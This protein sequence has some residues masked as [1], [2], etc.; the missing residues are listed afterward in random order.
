MLKTCPFEIDSTFQQGSSAVLAYFPGQPS[1]QTLL[2]STVVLKPAFLGSN[3]SFWQGSSTDHSYISRVVSRA[4]W[5]CCNRQLSS[6][7]PFLDR[8][9]DLANVR[10]SP[11]RARGQPAMNPRPELSQSVKGIAINSKLYLLSAWHLCSLS[12]LLMLY[13]RDPQ[14]LA[15]PALLCI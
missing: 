9:A 6:N 13:S 7:L 10:S 14:L 12:T 5:I 15:Y 4:R 11:R 1:S 8:M 2:Q 3:T